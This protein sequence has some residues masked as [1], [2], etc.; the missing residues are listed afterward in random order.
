[1]FSSIRDVTSLAI[2]SLCLG[3]G[4]NLLQ[5]TTEWAATYFSRRNSDTRLIWGEAGIGRVLQLCA[6]VGNFADLL[7]VNRLEAGFVF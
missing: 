2:T 3:M 4:K 7:L 5:V 6:A 1:M